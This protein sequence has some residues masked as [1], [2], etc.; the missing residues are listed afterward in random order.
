MMLRYAITDRK[1]LAGTTEPMR[2]LAELAERWAAA[3]VDWIQLREKD[4]LPGELEKVA[5]AMVEAIAGRG[6]RLLVNGRVDVA[7][8]CG[9]D[10]V[11]L[12]AQAG[13]L[14]VAQVRA[15]W[16]GVGVVSVACHTVEEVERARE[17][18]A[19]L[20]IFGPVF[21]KPLS[22]EPALPGVGLERLRD[23]CGAAGGMPVL[24][25]GGV[26]EANAEECVAVGAAGIAGIRLF[27][28]I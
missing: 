26:T 24:A 9:A 5:R 6:T 8:A 22:D 7:L 21:E 20:V 1:L 13:E 3:G 17:M 28:G 19:D 4:L 23:A 14:T 12:T 11:H 18:G 25:L 16:P 27:A 10:G 15:I 2:A